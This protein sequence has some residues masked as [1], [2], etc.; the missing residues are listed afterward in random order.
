MPDL[1]GK[2][3]ILTTMTFAPTLGALIIF[4]LPGKKNAAIKWTALAAA[5]VP[6]LCIWPLLKMYDTANAGFQLTQVAKW[7]KIGSGQ[8]HYHVGV[9]GISVTMAI[10]TAMISFICVIASWGFEHWHTTRGIKGYF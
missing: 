5:A 10:L 9:D 1:F 7:I 4:F 6:A 8:I 3:W 2:D